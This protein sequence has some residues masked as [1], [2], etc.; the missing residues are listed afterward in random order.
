MYEL[1]QEIDLVITINYQGEI[2]HGKLKKFDPT[3]LERNIITSE[4][5]EK[6]IKYV[7]SISGPIKLVHTTKIFEKYYVFFVDV[8]FYNSWKIEL[9]VKTYLDE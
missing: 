1:D 5:A 7:K 8:A 4:M 2:L 9:N 6:I 3:I